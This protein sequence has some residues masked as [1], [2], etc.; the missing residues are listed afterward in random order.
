MPQFTLF[1]L[2]FL[3]SQMFGQIGGLKTF[4]FLNLT[5]S[6]RVTALG[7]NLI[8]VYDNDLSLVNQNPALLNPEMHKQLSFNHDIYFA[9]ISHGYVGY[10][11]EWDKFD[12]NWAGGIQYI[13][14]GS[15]DMT[16]EAGNILGT[17]K[18]GEYAFNVAA[19]RQ[20]ENYSIGANVK[21]IYSD[22]GEFNAIGT[23]IDLGATLIDTSNLFAASLVIK[24]IGFMINQYS[25]TSRDELPFE[26]QLGFS[27]RLRHLPFRFS[28]V[29]HN[30]QKFDIRF[31]DPALSQSNNIFDIDTLDSGSKSFTGDK[32]LRHFIFG[33]EL[34]LSENFNVRFGYNHL[35]RKELMLTN[36]G[37]AAGFSVGF[38]VRVKK[39]HLS[40]GK[41]WYHYAGSTNHFGL[42]TKL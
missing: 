2:L 42:T 20:I 21:L 1:I 33:G 25:E 35:R 26:I 16:D 37:G 13:Q 41:A 24:N 18:A 11:T 28:I 30:L 10:A 29:A 27:K 23:A 14:Y 12:A 15:F 9:D 31:D 36:G 38:G 22:L 7:G 8:S 17:F 34:L 32:I 3:S 40:Y 6:A 5:P 39:F 4:Q 19:S